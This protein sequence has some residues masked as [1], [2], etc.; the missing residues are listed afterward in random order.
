MALL[1][2]EANEGLEVNVLESRSAMRKK[3]V[4]EDG[5]SWGK[6]GQICRTGFYPLY[7][8]PQDAVS[9]VR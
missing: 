5:L 8:A 6:G 4:L 1:D 7:F 9:C 2:N 3:P